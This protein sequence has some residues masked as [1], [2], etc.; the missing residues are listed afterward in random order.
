MDSG[1][2]QREVDE[3]KAKKDEFYYKRNVL[4]SP[5]KAVSYYNTDAFHEIQPKFNGAM[6][7][8]DAAQAFYKKQKFEVLLKRAKERERTSKIAA[9]EDQARTGTQSVRNDL[10]A[11]AKALDQ[12]TPNIQ[13]SLWSRWRLKVGTQIFPR[14]FCRILCRCHF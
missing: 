1:E 10:F 14:C 4:G 5:E 2:Q 11:A 3:W 6:Y 12:N 9:Y 7:V 8:R 13:A